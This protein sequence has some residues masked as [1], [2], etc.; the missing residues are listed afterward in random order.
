MAFKICQNEFRP[1]PSWGSSDL[2]DGWGVNY[3]PHAQPHSVPSA[4]CN[5]QCI[6]LQMASGLIS[7]VAIKEEK[8]LSL[9]D[10]SCLQLIVLT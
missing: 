4:Y 6:G 8:S 9:T 3:P 2:S 5:R 10:E 7:F 1:R